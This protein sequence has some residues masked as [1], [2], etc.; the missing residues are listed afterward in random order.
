MI[1]VLFEGQ[2]RKLPAI[3]TLKSLFP[4]DL[5]NQDF[6]N[7]LKA[8]KGYLATNNINLLNEYIDQF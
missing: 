4:S 3:M 8:T 7:Y 6:A 2:A 1:K 5:G